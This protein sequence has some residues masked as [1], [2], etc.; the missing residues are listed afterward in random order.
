MVR[1]IDVPEFEKNKAAL[2]HFEQQMVELGGIKG[3]LTDSKVLQL[4]SR[5]CSSGLGERPRF[6]L[7]EPAKRSSWL[8][9]GC[10]G[11]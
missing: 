5:T 7:G 4:M 9:S 8:P 6:V 1:I 3:E 10:A 2:M 11:G